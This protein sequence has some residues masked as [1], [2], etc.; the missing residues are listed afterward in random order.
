MTVL[1]RRA[2][3]GDQSFITALVRQARLNPAGLYWE[4]FVVAESDGRPVGIAQVRLHQDGTKELASLMVE[5][6][7]RSHGIATRMVDAL[8]AEETS[9]VYVLLDRRYADHFARWGFSQVEPADL[10]RSISRNY[11]IGRLVTTLGSLVRRQRIRIVPL[12][13]PAR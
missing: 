13:R 1:V 9:P 11:R 6:A 5:P 4:S 12:L 10:P 3:A 8:L 7:E 2:R